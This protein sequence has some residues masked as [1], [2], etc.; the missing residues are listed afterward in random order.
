MTIQYYLDGLS[1]VIFDTQEQ[2]F[3]IVDKNTHRGSYVRIIND[4]LDQSEI[5]H[6]PY[7]CTDGYYIANMEPAVL[8]EQIERGLKQPQI[9]DKQRALLESLKKEV[10]E[11]HNNYILYA[12]LKTDF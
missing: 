11:N 8:M 1:F 7:A 3:I 6:F 12:K 4:Y 9:T 2:K 5:S 10:D